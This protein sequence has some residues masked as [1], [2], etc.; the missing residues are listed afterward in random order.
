[1]EI[2][3]MK[4]THKLI[5]LVATGIVLSGAAMA[6][7]PS[8]L[9]LQDADGDRGILSVGTLTATRTFTFPDASGTML[10]TSGTMSASSILRTNSD[11]E[12]ESV[13]LNDGQLLIGS[14]GVPPQAGS[15]SGSRGLTVTAGAGTISLGMPTASV[16][17][18]LL[19]YDGTDW[20]S[21]GNGLTTSSDGDLTLGSGSSALGGSLV[22][23][24]DAT[25]SSF[26]G[27]IS[28]AAFTG[29]RTYELPDESGTLVVG[30][31]GSKTLAAGTS[32]NNTVRWNAATSSWD[33]TSKLTVSTD[34][35]ILLNAVTGSPDVLGGELRIRQTTG[36]ASNSDVLLR[37]NGTGDA[38]AELRLGYNGDDGDFLLYS[39]NVA[40]EV[41][42]LK[43]AGGLLTMGATSH[44]FQVES[45]SG[46][47]FAKV[48]ST[49]IIL[50]GAVTATDGTV[51]VGTQEVT[52]T[53]TTNAVRYDIAL[54][55]GTSPY[56]V[57]STD[58]VIIVEAGI[59]EVDLPAGATGR[60]LIIKNQSGGAVDIDPNGTETINGGA[61]GAVMNL[62][63]GAATHLVF[64]GTNWYVVGP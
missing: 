11:G 38:V 62:A 35:D 6:Q 29:D 47:E 31:A 23:H 28:T 46:S 30:A 40:V 33:E 64:N 57:A 24:D 20:V 2:A 36:D 48:K 56:A 55:G 51:T 5:A 43:T 54:T 13:T 8:R 7:N 25:G 63:D 10:V 14:T 9:Q 58:H 49:N 21:I 60:A 22:F 19:R 4:F 44:F 26:T 3:H 27:T 32:N 45:T 12:I 39:K 18:T 17:G 52:T 37:A 34:G 1:M 41:L 59:T 15:L 50:D 61:A 16:T 42:E 53:L